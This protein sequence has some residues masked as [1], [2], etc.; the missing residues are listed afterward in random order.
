MP[1]SALMSSFFSFCILFCHWV[2][3]L[4]KELIT[5]VRRFGTW[6]PWSTFFE[7]P[8]KFKFQSFKNSKKKPGCSQLYTLRLCKFI[9]RNTLYSVLK[10]TQT[11]EHKRCRFFFQNLSS[12]SFFLSLHTKVFCIKNLHDRSVYSWLHLNFL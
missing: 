9:M 2:F 1:I 6:A 3:I 10:K 11:W 7:H 5:R 8:K 4:W 12:L